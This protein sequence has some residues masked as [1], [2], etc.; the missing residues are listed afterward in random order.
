MVKEY[1]QPQNFTEKEAVGEK[2]KRTT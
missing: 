2:Q 1:Y